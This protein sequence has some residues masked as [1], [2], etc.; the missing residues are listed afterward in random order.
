MFETSFKFEKFI[1]FAPLLLSNMDRVVEEYIRQ[2]R[3]LNVPLMEQ[4]NRL[5]D[6][7]LRAVGTERLS[8]YNEMVGM[9]AI[10]LVA[11]EARDYT[12]SNIDIGYAEAYESVGI[13]KDGSRFPML[14]HGKDVKFKGRQLR[15][16]AVRDL[17]HLKAVEQELIDKNKVLEEKERRLR[18]VLDNIKDVFFQTDTVGNWTYLNEAWKEITGFEVEKTLGKA[19][20]DYV[21]ADDQEANLHLFMG[22]INRTKDYCR[23]VVRYKTAS[24]EYKWIDVHARLTLDDEDNIVGTTGTLRD[25]TDSKKA[26]LEI[27]E[28]Y[29][30]VKKAEESLKLINNQ[31]EERVERRTQE[32]ES[33]NKELN[34]INAKLITINTDLDN[35]I[36][37]ASHDLKAPIL[38]LEGLLNALTKKVDVNN[39]QVANILRMMNGSVD[40]F[41]NTIKDLTEISKIQKNLEEEDQ[42]KIRFNEILDDVQSDIKELI[43]AS[44][45]EIIS[46][47]HQAPQVLFSRK[48]MRSILYNLLSNSIKY[49]AL[50]RKSVVVVKTEQND[51]ATIT[52]SVKDNGLGLNPSQVDQV[53]TMFKRMHT[54]VEGS[55]V[56]LYIVKRM[57]ENAGGKIEVQSEEG[58]GTEFR[59]HLQNC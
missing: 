30:K 5:S 52:L 10:K 20:L 39:P 15:V 9:E 26:E 2:L 13:R 1:E 21:H 48:N 56:G 31:L 36:Y 54:H 29:K 59:V 4:L 33:K 34:T 7:Q 40:R 57:V 49:R 11:P 55:G 12:K 32:L 53:F 16:T 3:A 23:H 42:E 37:T 24:G 25:I 19:L 22:L 58:V 43:E 18:N 35:F 14:L 44:E 38:N 27:S 8:S 6:E 45:A 41:K 51:L 46:D 50:D 17:T 28:A 47:F